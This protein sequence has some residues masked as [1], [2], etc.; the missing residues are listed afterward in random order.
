MK[1]WFQAA[2]VMAAAGI[3]MGLAGV[4]GSKQKET[5]VS[6][7]VLEYTDLTICLIGNAPD[8]IDMV[9][10]KFNE[11]TKRDL[12]C[13][14]Q[15]KWVVWGDF[16]TKYP[17]LLSIGEN[18]DL[19]YAANWLDFY[20]NAQ[21]GAFAPLEE[22]LET[23]APKS[24]EALTDEVRERATVNGH[25]Y[26]LPANYSN[27]NV[28]GAIVRGDLMEKY[29]IESIDT[30]A[31][32]L[33]FCEVMAEEEG[34]DPTGMCSMNMDMINLYLMEKGYYPV[35]G[36]T[37]CPY[38]INLNDKDYQVYFQSECPGVEEFLEKAKTWYEK[39]YWSSNVL[40]SKDETLLDS[41]LAASRIHN[42]DA[43]LGEYGMHLDWDLQYYNLVNPIVRQTALQDAMAIPAS[44]GKK[45]RA[46]MLL[47]KLR[48]EE[49]YYMLLTYGIEGYHYRKE[50]RSI[51]FLN[52][53]YGN[54]P[55][56]WGFR[57]EKFKCWD[58]VLPE[59]AI[60]LWEEFEENAVDTPLV[61]FDLDLS[62]IQTEY[63]AVKEVMSVYYNPLKLG[64]IEYE[65]GMQT[66]E[67]QLENAGNEEVKQE[68]QRQIKAFIEN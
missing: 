13:T 17:M 64:Y 48:N 14:V 23:Y 55:G 34:I 21:R 31:D 51:E 11:L 43:Y 25:L 3:L 47:E 40:A 37:V 68:I 29:Q 41:G 19:I 50:G 62:R 67:R 2:I 39:G 32:Y 27:Y 57:E 42:Y 12:N 59:E 61:D 60:G 52:G 36:S 33:E 4:S 38:W 56:T 49:E 24:R 26:A 22:L 28:L 30:F 20:E 6:E 18:I 1:R 46:M 16:E 44:S 10:E 66:L 5:K 8:D 9:M 35:D 7:Q 53:D 54:E 45:E 65:E 58:S 63:A 15:I